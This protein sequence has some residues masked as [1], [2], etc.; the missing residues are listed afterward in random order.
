VRPLLKGTHPTHGFGREVSEGP[1]YEL[2]ALQAPYAQRVTAPLAQVAA[3]VLCHA[4][5]RLGAPYRA[6][7]LYRTPISVVPPS[8]APVASPET[9][10]R[11]TTA[12]DRSIVSSFCYL[13]QHAAQWSGASC[14]NNLCAGAPKR[15]SEEN[16]A[17]RLQ[18]CKIT[19]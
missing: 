4:L 8:Q 9:W 2:V 18:P 17:A 19:I 3:Q 12:L 16:R 1:E 7:P 15:V 14:Q 10:H 6:G 5:G 13:F 11:A